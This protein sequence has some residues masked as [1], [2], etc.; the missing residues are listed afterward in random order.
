MRFVGGKLSKNDNGVTVKTPLGSLAIRGGI[1]Q[2][3]F[4]PSTSIISFIYG[5][6][7]RLTLPSGRDLTAF[8]PGY[9]IEPG[10][11]SDPLRA[12]ILLW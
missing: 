8:E 10:L 5:D 9:T 2:A 12:A 7:A 6:Y 3:A 11:V 4:G 1:V